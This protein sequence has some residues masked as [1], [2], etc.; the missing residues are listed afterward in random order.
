MVPLHVFIEEW[1]HDIRYKKARSVLTPCSRLA[2][3][4]CRDTFRFLREVRLMAAQ[5][6]GLDLEVADHTQDNITLMRRDLTK[7]LPFEADF[8]D[9]VTMLA[10]LEHIEDPRPI[11]GE[12]FRVLKSGGRLV[13]TTPTR[14]GIYVH[15][16]MV[17]SKLVRDV[18]PGEHKDFAMSARVLAGWVKEAGFVVETAEIFECGLNVF[19]SARKP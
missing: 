14:F 5:C 2:D 15:D 9:V 17:W 1:G 19:V 18:E 8:L 12:C 7:T 4:G 11:L 6:W 3:L 10:V 13:L 16:F